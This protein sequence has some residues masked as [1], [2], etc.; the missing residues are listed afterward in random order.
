MSSRILSRTLLMVALTGSAF[1][2]QTAFARSEPIALPS[3]KVDATAAKGEQVAI[4]AGGCFWAVEGVFDKVKGVRQA[5]SGYSGGTKATADY[6]TVSTGNTGHAEAV[7]ITYDPSQVSYG[8]LLK[9]YFSVVHDP[10][11]LNRQSPDVGPQYRSEVFTTNAEQAKV[12][13][14]YIAQLD[15]AKAFKKP[16]VTKVA[17]LQAFYVAEDYHQNY[18]VHHPDQPYIV[19][20]D[21]P[22]IEHLKDMFPKLY[23]GS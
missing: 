4:F 16:I 1:A 6:A 18:M 9:I 3:A 13:K 22:K 14:A 21:A 17:P 19:Y 11:Q 20:N 15:A 23:K 7:Q 12:A 2:M 5:V 8:Q 10:T